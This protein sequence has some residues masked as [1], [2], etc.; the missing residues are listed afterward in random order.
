VLAGISKGNFCDMFA[1]CDAI[2]DNNKRINCSKKEL[3]LFLVKIRQG[4]S[5]DF[6]KVMFKYSTRQI[7]SWNIACVRKTLT[8]KFVKKHLG[9]DAITRAE[10]VEKHIS[11]FSNTLHNSDSDGNQKEKVAMLIIDGTYIYIPKSS[12]YTILRQSFPVHKGRHLIKP[13]M[14][15]APDGYILDVH[16][17][18]WANGRNNDAS[19]LIDQ[20]KKDRNGLR[21]WLQEN[22]IMIVDR[23][24]RDS[25]DFLESLN[26]RTKMPSYLRKGNKQHTVEEANESRLVTKTRWVVE[27]RNGHIKSKFKFFRDMVPMQHV[28]N[29]GDFF[30]IACAIINAYSPPIE[31]KGAN[32]QLARKMLEKAKESNVMQCRV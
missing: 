16:G 7:V 6:L 12:N 4:L 29:V 1:E 8:A 22:D 18:Y 26:I 20:L 30:R 11:D 14:I 19:C 21:Q 27:A 13:I 24:Y 9:L 2:F 25:L 3:L 17:P 32:E 23:G 10:Y 5:D 15:C 28:E 31:M